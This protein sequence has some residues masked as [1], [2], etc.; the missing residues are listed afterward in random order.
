VPADTGEVEKINDEDAAAMP[1][2]KKKRKKR[3]KQ[4]GPA[5][6]ENN[7]TQEVAIALLEG[8]GAVASLPPIE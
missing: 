7:D 4:E 3:A 1:K 5:V 6:D 2:A 8:A